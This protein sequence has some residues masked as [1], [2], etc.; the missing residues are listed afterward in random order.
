MLKESFGNVYSYEQVKDGLTYILFVFY[1]HKYIYELG[2]D[3]GKT[4]IL[5]IENLNVFYRI[6]PAGESAWLS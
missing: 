4:V 6:C 5:I 3:L 2:G 1:K